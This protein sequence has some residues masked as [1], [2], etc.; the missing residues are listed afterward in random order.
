[1]SEV[2]LS[3]EQMAELALDNLASGI[4][5][6][7]TASDLGVKPSTLR[8][9]LMKSEETFA[10]Y[11]IARTMMGQALAEKALEIASRTTVQTVAADRLKIDTLQ[12]AAARLS[13]VEWGDK[14]MV[15]TEG[16]QTVEVRIVEESEEPKRAIAVVVDGR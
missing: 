3:R 13:P 7:K 6:S 12:W 14:Q 2:Q 10:Q 16:H 1:M 11:Q 5:L 9:M 15:H 8:K 4:P